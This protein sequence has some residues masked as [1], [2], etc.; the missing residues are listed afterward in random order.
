MTDLIN[1]LYGI[2]HYIITLYNNIH[3]LPWILPSETFNYD[4]LNQ[5]THFHQNAL[6]HLSLALTSLMSV[7]HVSS[8]PAIASPTSSVQQPKMNREILIVPS[9][10]RRTSKN[11]N[12]CPPEKTDR[13]ARQNNSLCFILL[14]EKR[15]H[16]TS[17]T[18]RIDGCDA[19][20]DIKPDTNGTLKRDNSPSRQRTGDII[21][22]K[23]DRT[24]PTSKHSLK[25]GIKGQKRIPL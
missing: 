5:H 14:R 15:K 21:T 4:I 22:E 3:S 9:S 2:L 6:P 23:E 11:K 18:R 10:H 12:W 24:K 1:H 19:R 8:L 25:P 17:A 7:C 16:G 20:R 13:P